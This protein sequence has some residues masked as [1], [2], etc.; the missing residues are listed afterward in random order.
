MDN[1]RESLGSRLGFILLS[2][3]CAI[4]LG[5]VW[6]FPYKVGNNGG[7]AFVFV[8]ILCVLVLG[9]PIMAAEFAMGRASR[10]SPI[11][12]Y[13]PLL[14]NEKS[15]F[16]L[17]GWLSLAGNMFLM[18]FY[19]TIAGYFFH[20]LV[21]FV[22]GNY[23]NLTWESTISNV[24]VNVGFM[25]LVVVLGFVILS[26]DIQ[27]G[28]EKVT[29]W[30][31]LALFLLMIVLAVHSCTLS[32][33]GK[34]IEFYLK[35]DFSQIT[36][37]VIIAAM[38]Q[39]FF[40]LSLGMGSMAIFGSYTDKSRSLLGEAVNVCTLDTLVALLAGFIIFP[41]CFTF[42]ID[43]N[44]GP[45]LL[46]T[47]MVTVF[48]NMAGGRVWGALFF[49][50]MIFAAMS[51]VVAVFE[52]ILAMVRELTGWSRRKGCLL[53]CLMMLVLCT[54]MALTGNVLSNV[55][56]LGGSTG[57]LDLWDFLVETVI[58]PIGSVLFLLVCTNDKLWGWDK[59]TAE[60]NTGAGLKVRSWM[61]VIFKYVTPVIVF[62]IW[63]YG[64]VSFFL[65]YFAH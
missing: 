63:I 12:M 42:G 23:E 64:L 11:S 5:N 16:H 43:P 14:K 50:F 13:R 33:F 60:S 7:G 31:M 29:K 28:L 22:S 9:V 8:Y 57:F 40:S 65:P 32:G 26:F 10:R 34:G 21:G 20:Y 54:P 62:C 36:P 59:F 3:G 17:Q 51:T 48:G 6:S 52:N 41:A 45:P 24:G 55:H 37:S 30:M 39:A 56:P 53:C 15:P 58:Q 2:A 35:P 19:T 49:I 27:K 61:K 4:G 18:M 38:C 25:I 46:F 44:A 1:K 47:T